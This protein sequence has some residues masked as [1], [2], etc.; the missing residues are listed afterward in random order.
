MK[1]VRA[2]LIALVVLLVL[3]AVAVG[4]AL[5]P[6][7]Q[8]WAVMRAVR[9][10]PGLQ[11]EATT[12][13]A[14][15]SQLRFAGV[16]ASKDG[17]TIQ[18][19]RL[20]ADYSP[21]QLLFRRRLVLDHVQGRG[22]V[23]DASLLSGD[24]TGAAAVGA[25]AAAPGLL[26][27]IELP[28]ALVMDNCVIDGQ[29]IFPGPHGGPPLAADFKI[30][31]GKFAPGQE[32]ELL[33]VATL[34]NPAASRATRL[35]VSATL[36]ARQTDRRTFDRAGINA[37][38]Q[39][40]GSGLSGSEQLKLVADLK[41]GA[42]GEQ[43]A[44]SVDTLIEGKPESV[45]A[46]H[47]RL[48]PGSRD[49]AGDWKLVAHTAQLRSFFLGAAL[50]DFNVRGEGRFT[51]DPTIAAG[52]LQGGLEADVRR[53]EA[54]EPAWRA[55]GPVKL[56]ARFDFAA[57]DA[58]ARLNQLHVTLAGESPV[59]ELSAARAAEINFKERRLQVGGSEAGEA[60]ALTLHGLPLAW[61]RPF[62]KALDVSGGL[63]T[64]QL[65]INGEPDRLL[66]RAVQPLRVQG[67]NVVKEG[68]ALLTRADLAA[69]FEAVLTPAELQAT[70]TEF[71]LKTPA[72]DSLAANAKVTL[73]VVPDP[74]VTVVASYTADLPTLLAP[75]VPLGRV[76]AAG[77][78]DFTIEGKKLALRRLHAGVADAGGL[79]LFKVAALRPFHFDLASH[80]A[81]VEEMT[82]A[83]DLL[84]VILG[85]IPLTALPINLAGA[86]FG[87]F[88]AR[89][90][91]LISIDG[92]KLVLSSPVALQLA[93]VSLVDQGRAALAG[94]AVEARPRLEFN[95]PAG[96]QLDTGDI[97][98]RNAAGD[99]VLTAKGDAKRL[100]QTGLQAAMTFMFE[101]PALGS[102]PLF[103]GAKAVNAG[104]ASGEVRMA[105]GA[106]NQVE[107]RMTVN[108]LVA[109]G[110]GEPL[111]IA[112][113]SFR[114]VAQP[115][116][117]VNIQAPLLLDRS[118]QRSD[119]N[120]TLDVVPAGRGV[121]FDGAL[122]GEHVEL[123]DALDLLG[124]FMAS[125]AGGEAAPKTVGAKSANVTPDGAPVWSR[126]TGRL[127]L[128]VK[129]VARGTEWSMTGLTG[130]V[131]VE[132]ATVKLEKLEAAFGDKGRLAAK[133]LLNFFPGERP[134]GLD[135][136]FSLTEFDAGKLFKALDP[137]KPATVEGIFSVHG[138]FSGH[139]ETIGRTIERTR[140]AFDLTSR[141]GV[142]RGL[143]RTTSRVSM[144]SKAVELGASVLGSIFGSENVT[145]TA[146]KVAGQAYFVDQ[147]AQS[148][149]ELNYDQLSVRIARDES[150]NVALEDI[151]L[152]S[153][154]IRLVGKGTVT[155]MPGKPL[156]EQ[157]L[158]ASLSIAG[159]GKIEEL[160]GKLRLLNGAKDELGY[161][162]T[163]EA[164]TLGGS[165]GRPDPTA[166]FTRIATAKLGDLL[167]P[168]N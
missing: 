75:W 143:Q 15:W 128:D 64:G 76:K 71:S 5:T 74:A 148:V 46:I 73:P 54:I 154:E 162:R 81:A 155:Y 41:R 87:G 157:P 42:D 6:S 107:A 139:G 150:L 168:E 144:T 40:E 48:A 51:F 114:A 83:V 160:L 38:V 9:S 72:G 43:Y 111:P 10:Q 123:A 34:S 106:A 37:L 63:I 142:F 69:A 30:T 70:V 164:V 120:F 17:V 149:G 8:R 141:A 161:A 101:V 134:Y 88:V 49:Y 39:A 35:R 16:K 59:L 32:G 67:L 53:L 152:V 135:G 80:Q 22:L 24:K 65:A 1:L 110:T 104:R 2:L 132:P 19:D 56:T 153:P 77:E 20:E 102:Q 138:K 92:Q 98:V 137:A 140:G 26:T 29:A 129:S 91:F 118:G 31:G 159:R 94:L 50:P 86:R 99:T 121:A 127:G 4:L 25:P 97:I 93:D 95:G 113:L 36:R 84:Q 21:A 158:N 85:R 96:G 109:A 112:N 79:D 130:L 166:F 167:A 47:A 145:K 147:L 61:V 45:L 12:I 136:D 78:A 131:A 7:V 62:V 146:E 18:L 133:G 119:L 115:D 3:G 117:R 105:L 122:R 14:G 82:G 125:M 68:A 55:I 156:L 126:F 23:V 58:I 52:S 33:L 66:L 165:L 57:S 27:R 28:V 124:V 163:K 116:G 60:L 13:A 89:G 90:E 108:G 100:P 103:A 11:V 151:S 44:V